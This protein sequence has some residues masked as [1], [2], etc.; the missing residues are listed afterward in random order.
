MLEIS[1][2]YINSGERIGGSVRTRVCV[3]VW[4]K[5]VLSAGMRMAH[6]SVK[7]IFVT[8]LLVCL[9]AAKG[10]G[11]QSAVKSVEIMVH[12]AM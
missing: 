9:L 4:W 1:E 10:K 6:V 5:T 11:L 3:C 12:I 8:S 2:C 7:T